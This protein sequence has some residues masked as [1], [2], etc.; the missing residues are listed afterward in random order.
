M[1]IKLYRACSGEEVHWTVANMATGGASLVVGAKRPDEKAA[2]DY[3]G[4]HEGYVQKY[5][6]LSA[7]DLSKT[8]KHP[9][10]SRQLVEYTTN[11]KVALG[12]GKA[13]GWIR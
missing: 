5:Q 1:K 11:P 8:P 10:T 13:T 12:F 4:T 9:D 2:I 6:P 3:V 7:Q